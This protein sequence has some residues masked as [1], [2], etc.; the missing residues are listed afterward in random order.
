MMLAA[1]INERQEAEG[2][3]RGRAATLVAALWRARGAALAGLGLALV[4]TAVALSALPPRWT[5][6]TQI[7]LEAR[8]VPAPGLETAA[9]APLS[10]QTIASE[11][12]L[13]LS[14]GL[15][16]DVAAGLRLEEELAAHPAARGDALARLAA[17]LSTILRARLGWTP[18]AAPP[19]PD[20]EARRGVAVDALH[21]MLS[22]SRAGESRVLVLRAVD[23][24]PRR[25]ALIANAAADAFL[26]DQARAKREGAERGAAW[27]RARLSELRPRLIR[28]EG[29][30]DAQRLR[31]LAERPEGAA[32]RARLADLAAAR[33]GLTGRGAGTEDPRR[34]A[35]DA[36]IA[37]LAEE[38]AAEALAGAALREAEQEAAALRRMRDAFLDRLAEA[39][40]QAGLHRPDARVIAAAA[41]PRSPSGPAWPPALALAAVMGLL[42]GGL[43]FLAREALLGLPSNPAALAR[44]C[45][46]PIVAATPPQTARFPDL[47]EDARRRPGGAAAEAGRALRIVALHAAQLGA[48]RRGSLRDIEAGGFG[49][50]QRGIV[51]AVVGAAHG[52][53]ASSVAALLAE[54]LARMGRTVCL[55]DA[56]LRAPVQAARYS[57][58]AETDL[59]AVLDGDAP[60][61]NSLWPV[62]VPG[63]TVLPA[64]P[65]P[66]S[67]GEVLAEAGIEDLIEAL[68]G[69]FDAVVID[70]PAPSSAADGRLLAGLA[71]ATVLTMRWGR[72]GR[73]QARAAMA[74]L[75]SAGANPAAIALTDAR[76][77]AAPPVSAWSARAARYGRFAEGFE[78]RAAS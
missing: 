70:A 18:A 4:V 72:T 10:D 56:D 17:E 71:D 34:N 64:T 36:A 59:L 1:Q 22:V 20:A 15:L 27:L 30:A 76:G 45:G 7:L 35:L 23:T 61:D 40:A 3:L 13:L 51:V 48:A 26:A 75:A 38:A 28:A 58:E 50:R 21:A 63:L 24:S 55:V 77:A 57:L 16:E 42:G 69:R 6:Q 46:L 68:R 14:R 12:Q 73:A 37:A 11:A 62:D 19:I 47:A 65:A 9:H 41:P 39:E 66:P 29:V 52:V 54:S 33:D 53:G 5:A 78:D 60:L 31:G 74:A 25:A 67:R 32:A 2:G 8:G 44:M 43:V 49:A